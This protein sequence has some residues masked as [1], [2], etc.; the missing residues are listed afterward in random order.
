MSSLLI[1][2]K[3]FGLTN[4]IFKNVTICKSVQNM[5][6]LSTEA[7]LEDKAQQP[8]TTVDLDQFLDLNALPTRPKRPNLF[9]HFFEEK[10]AELKRSNPNVDR[11]TALNQIKSD[12]EQTNRDQYLEEHKDE[13]EAYRRELKLYRQLMNST[14]TVGEV[15]EFLQKLRKTVRPKTKRNES[16]EGKRNHFNFFIMDFANECKQKNVRFNLKDAAE[17]FKQLSES[18]KEKYRQMVH[19]Q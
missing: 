19:N 18:E 2:S 1:K 15:V 17:K 9:H 6:C 14:L 12:W 8:L 5:K 4:L 16:S 3:S 11:S 7:A 10:F 13:L